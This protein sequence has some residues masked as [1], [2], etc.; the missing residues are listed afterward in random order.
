MPKKIQY[1]LALELKAEVTTLVDFCASC[2]FLLE[3]HP[4]GLGCLAH[5][6]PSCLP[7]CSLSVIFL[8]L[9]QALSPLSTHPHSPTTTTT[10]ACAHCVLQPLVASLAPRLVSSQ[11]LHLTHSPPSTLAHHLL[12]NVQLVAALPSSAASLPVLLHTHLLNPPPLVLAF[13]LLQSGPY[14]NTP[15]PVPSP[16]EGTNI[17]LCKITR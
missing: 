14:L 2:E 4:T 9:E 16:Q 17:S 3:T 15:C 13:T 7:F 10:R 8:C 6:T 12:L 1:P 11:P 5:C